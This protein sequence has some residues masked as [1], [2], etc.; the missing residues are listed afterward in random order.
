MQAAIIDKKGYTKAV[1]YLRLYALHR[2]LLEYSKLLT[3][4]VHVMVSHYVPK[5]STN[6]TANAADHHNYVRDHT[7]Y[8]NAICQLHWHAPRRENAE[9]TRA[10]HL[11]LPAL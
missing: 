2:V 8:T 5:N 4:P 10:A 11:W 6:R 1:C 9:F 3:T 7:S